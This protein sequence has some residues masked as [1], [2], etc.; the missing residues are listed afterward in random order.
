V[1]GLV[2]NP[3]KDSWSLDKEDV[4]VNYVMHARQSE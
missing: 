1:T 4:D 3:V 2:Y